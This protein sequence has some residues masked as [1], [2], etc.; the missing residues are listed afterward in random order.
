MENFENNENIDYKK[1]QVEYTKEYCKLLE[2]HIFEVYNIKIK[3][4]NLKNIF[5]PLLYTHGVESMSGIQ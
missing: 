2:L 5:F 4:N 3:F 1:I